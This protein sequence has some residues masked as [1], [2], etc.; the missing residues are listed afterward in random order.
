ME[1]MKSWKHYTSELIHGSLLHSNHKSALFLKPLTQ[2]CELNV[3]LEW[4]RQ[5]THKSFYK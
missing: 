5:K 4:L 2:A 3:L 1:L